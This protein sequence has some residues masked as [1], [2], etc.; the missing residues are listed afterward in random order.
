MRSSLNSEGDATALSADPRGRTP[1][2]V[3]VM[4]DSLE[5]PGGG[6]R[7]AVEG[8]IRLDPERYERW[9]CITRWSDD[10]ERVEPAAGLLAR[11]EEAGVRI[12][13][14]RR[15]RRFSPFAWR[16]LIRV[17]RSGRVQVVHGHL[18][19]SN[20]WASVIGTLTRTPAIVAHEHMWA[21]SDGGARPFIDRN[22]IGRLADA[23]IAVSGEGRR[24]MLE[25]ERIP[26][27]KV[28]LM[29]NG[30]PEREPGDGARIR[31]ESGIGADAMV[32][33]SVGHLRAEKAYEVLI[34][35]VSLLGERHPGVQAL[36]AG[37]G[38][39]RGMLEEQRRRLGLDGSVH[40][41]GARDDVPDVLAALD[42]AVCCSDFE[43]GPL[44]V[45]EYM[46]AG[47]PVVAS[48][49][50]GL[51]ELVRAGETGLLV[52]PRDPRALA[53]ALAGLLDD[54]AER[55]RL[56][57]AGREL[58]RSVYGIDAWVGRLE[59]LYSSLLG[60]RITSTG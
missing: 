46:A 22:L 18:F 8:A 6:E 41:L 4:I 15:T 36:I 17:L 40:L 60:D 21:Y 9:L 42:V 48:D 47:L 53:D 7:L 23:F 57:D 5:N 49:V 1:I 24:Q 12:I 30:V 10:F 44:S 45:M 43:G 32:I 26:E 27:D 54:R 31:A 2:G 33:G 16:P 59:A 28:V 19:G 3:V 39:E 35:A 51:P 11:A 50:G 37:E 13:R 56:G 55:R 58:Q 34:E 52:P 29:P 25:L 14:V 20:V 38:P